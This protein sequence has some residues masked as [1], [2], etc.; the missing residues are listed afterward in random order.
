[1]KNALK[2]FKFWCKD[3]GATAAIEAGLLFPILVAL[4]C[5]TMDTGFGLIT[6]QKVINATQMV[7]DL[8]T[9]GTQVT[10]TDIDDAIVAGQMAIAPYDTTTYGIDIVGIQFVGAT[11]VPTE[12]WRRTQNMSANTT[13]LAKS[14]GMG[15]QDEGVVAVTVQYTYTPMFSGYFTGPM[16]MKEESYA[17]GRK[18]LFVAKV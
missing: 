2:I 10:T 9:R 6:S 17:R 5:G 15:A 13:V 11:L 18:G 3:D 14:A 16:I 8:M 1:M 12:R 4:L 7:S